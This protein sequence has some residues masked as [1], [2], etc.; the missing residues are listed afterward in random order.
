MTGFNWSPKW[1]Y[2]CV[3]GRLVFFTA[4][5][6]SDS[7]GTFNNHYFNILKITTHI[8]LSCLPNHSL[9]IVHVYE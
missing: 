1:L 6:T 3:S 2:M 5:Y 7:R 9:I 4:C 8:F